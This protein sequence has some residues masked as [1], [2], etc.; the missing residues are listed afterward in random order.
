MIHDAR[1]IPTDGAAQLP[2]AITRWLGSSRARWDRDTLVIETINFNRQ[3]TFHGSDERMH[4]T[5]RLSLQDPD[6]IRYEYTIDDLTAFTHS[7]TAAFVMTRSQEPMYEYACHEGNYG[8]QNT[9][10]FARGG[11]SPSQR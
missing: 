3:V 2:Q 8:L 6:T 5:E 10:R 7:W 1:I 9:L 4:V 11:D